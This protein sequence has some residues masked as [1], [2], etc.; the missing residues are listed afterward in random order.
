M[1]AVDDEVVQTVGYKDA[2][3]QLTCPECGE[4]VVFPF[5]VELQMAA[6]RDSMQI[7]AKIFGGRIN[8][9]PLL[10]HNLEGHG[11]DAES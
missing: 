8:E 11:P 1:A 7:D 9:Q 5:M 10:D 2:F 4:D 6:T 3:V